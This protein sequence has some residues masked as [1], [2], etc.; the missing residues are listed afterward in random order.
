MIQVFPTRNIHLVMAYPNAQIDLSM[1]MD[2]PPLEPT[3]AWTDLSTLGTI[4]FF[5][6][7]GLGATNP[8]SVILTASHPPS[9]T[10]VSLRPARVG[11][12]FCLH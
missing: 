12:A 4:T 7:P 6:F 8:A 5:A 11:S 10:G 9:P 2:W 3:Q 1:T